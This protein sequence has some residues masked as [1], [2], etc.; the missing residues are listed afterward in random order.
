MTE[1][2]NEEEF[3]K[4][5]SALSRKHGFVIYGCG[6]C[7]SPSLEKMTE[8]DRHCDSRYTYD[9]ILKWENK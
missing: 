8:V 2:K 3:L 1:D 7:G 4:S 6:C 5:L 9:D